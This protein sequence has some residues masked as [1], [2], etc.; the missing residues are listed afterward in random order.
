MIRILRYLVKDYKKAM[1]TLC[2]ISKRSKLYLAID[3][4]LCI[5][6][7][8]TLP[9]EYLDF[10]FDF[11]PRCK[12][13]DYFTLFKRT[14]AYKRIEEPR[15]GN[16]TANKFYFASVMQPFFGRRFLHTTD[17]TLED[18]RQFVDGQKKI[19]CKPVSGEGGEGHIIYHLDGSRSVEDLYNEI[20][21]LPR[22]LLETWIEQH[23]VLSALYPDAVNI[24]RLHTI[25][26]GN[27]DNIRFYGTNFSIA[28]KGE[29]ANTCL[30]NTISTQIDDE[31]GVINT[32]GFD[33]QYNI[34]K[35]TP[36]TNIT[37]RGYQL[38]YW[39][40]VLELC[41]RAA[42]RVPEM[43]LVGWDVAF[44]PDGPVL[45]EG[46]GFPGNCGVQSRCWV[47]EGVAFGVWPLVK[48]Y[49]KPAKK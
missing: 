14:Y 15:S 9:S 37:L 31:T 34:Y 18:F 8:L 1:K 33:S 22:S 19:I 11:I 12:R 6:F 21:A 29:L 30:D 7:H 25:H 3:M 38:P 36:G 28:F 45:V 35:K 27:L 39:D 4:L 47:E 44:T 24:A 40:E 2:R 17:M 41:R 46:N 42:A 20:K 10:G 48:S 5:V 13:K 43:R 49:L 16:I 32:D 26:D 23:E